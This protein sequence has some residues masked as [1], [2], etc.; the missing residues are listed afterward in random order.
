MNKDT[1]GGN[2]KQFKGEVQRQWGK[3]TNDQLDIIEGNREKLA[4]QIQEAYGVAKDEA[5]RQV[6]EFNQRFKDDRAA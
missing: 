3:L 4:G 6:R 1:L 2:W 5:E